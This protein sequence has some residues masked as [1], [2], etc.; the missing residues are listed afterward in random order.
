MAKIERPAGAN[1]P[2]LDYADF[3]AACP[4]EDV[5][6]VFNGIQLMVGCRGCRRLV[7]VEALGQRLHVDEAIQDKGG[8]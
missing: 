8:K 2:G 6:V 3:H 5:Y 1:P 4:K 7:P